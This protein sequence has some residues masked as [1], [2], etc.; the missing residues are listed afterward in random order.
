MAIDRNKNT[1]NPPTDVL[2]APLFAGVKPVTPDQNQAAGG[3]LKAPTSSRLKPEQDPAFQKMMAG[4]VPPTDDPFDAKQMRERFRTMELISRTREDLTKTYDENL[5]Q[6][7]TQQDLTDKQELSE[8]DITMADTRDA[9]VADT[10]VLR[11]ISSNGQSDRYYTGEGI[12][13]FLR[14]NPNHRNVE[15][16]SVGAI[17]HRL[18][19]RTL[20]R[21][22]T[23]HISYS[24]TTQL[25]PDLVTRMNKD[26]QVARY[27]ALT[28]SEAAKVGIDGNML[29]NQFWQESRFNPR[30]KSGAGA[31]GIAQMMPFQ[32]GKYGLE[33]A[34]DFYNPEKSIAAGAQMMGRLTAEYGDQ[35][36]ALVAY[37]GGGK[38]IDFVEKSTGKKTVSFAE[39]HDFMTDRRERLGSS[40]R[41]AWHVETLDYT[42]KI[43]LAA[44][45]PQP[46]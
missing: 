42:N 30:A 2:T 32:E 41:G 13:S 46:S 4:I 21:T 20:D 28:Q 1:K 19:S 14:A 10:P 22:E 31:M 27:V 25:N 18:I 34:A 5:P 43:A 35:R 45:A 23:A 26:P 36:L 24:G 9:R 39:W 38:A 29:A 7:L 12:S 16:T 33:S 44:P 3:K 15:G 11:V 40:N 37:N 6:L 17:Q 8:D